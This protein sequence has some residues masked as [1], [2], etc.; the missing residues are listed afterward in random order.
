MPHQQGLQRESAAGSLGQLTAAGQLAKM[1]HSTSQPQ[2]S[3]EVLMYE[4][5]WAVGHVQQFSSLAAAPM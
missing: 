3:P 5:G 2:R 4:I 1:S